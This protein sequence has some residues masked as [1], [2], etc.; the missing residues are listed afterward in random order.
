MCTSVFVSSLCR[1]GIFLAGIVCPELARIA[2]SLAGFAAPLSAKLG[3]PGP[4]RETVE[5]VFVGDVMLAR[6]L[7]PY[8]PYNPKPLDYR[9]LFERVAP[10]VQHA[11]IAFCN[12]ESPISGRGQRLGKK[13]AFNAP[14][15]AARG[16]AE[17]GFDVVSL[18]NNHCLDFGA[19]ALSDTLE[20]LDK[21]KVKCAG[22]STGRAPQEPV[23][24]EVKGVRIAYLAYQDP[25]ICP[26]EFGT[27]PTRP[28]SA[29]K[30]TIL[31]DIARVR[32][33]ADLL[34][35]SLHWGIEDQPKPNAAH[36]QLAHAVIDAGAHIVAGHHPHVQQ[37]PEIY[38]GRLIIYSMGN[39]V[40]A[41]YSEP[42]ARKTRLYRVCAN[43]QGVIHAEYLPLEIDNT[44][45]RPEPKSESFVPVPLP[46]Q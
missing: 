17:A 30:E 43:K 12:L 4:P 10:Y 39:F 34:V 28:A 2:L 25:N 3:F 6:N 32:S 36:K 7:P 16:L 13:Y 41:L 33:Q 44:I 23:L 15:E 9:F 20:N 18:A 38:N 5:L 24:L 19:E 22:L 14:P 21:H 37:E 40:F 31:S 35:V 11:D 29:K 26:P 27:F 42:P 46:P 1:W 45:T 8:A